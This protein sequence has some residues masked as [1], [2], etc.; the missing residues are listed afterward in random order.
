MK[1]FIMKRRNQ[2]SK[3]PPPVP[4]DNPRVKPKAPPK[5]PKPPSAPVGVGKGGKAAGK[6]KVEIKTFHAAV[7]SG[8][9]Q[10]EKIL[11][12]ADSGLGKSTLGLL[13][14]TPVF[15]GLDDGGRKLVHPITGESPH[16]I[17][18]VE[19]F[20]DF[21]QATQQVDLF[22]DYETVVI[23]TA[24]ILES[25]AHDW[26]LEN[27]TNNKGEFVK[28]IEHYGYGAGHRH[29]YD[30]MRLPLCDFDALVRRGKNILILC[31]MQQI[32]ITNSSGENYLCDAPKLA[33]K[34]GKQTP[35]VWGMWVEWCDHVFKIG[36]SDLKAKDK[37][38]T[39]SSER[40]IFLDG[41]VNFKAKSR[42]VPNQFPLVTFSTPEDDSIWKFIFEDAWRDLLEEK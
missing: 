15:L 13:A 24:T 25:W 5:P 37:K 35:S 6:K 34:H 21:Q 17:E 19:T 1:Y 14:P 3:A 30:T 27:V 40:I 8:E 33:P 9:G 7:W 12:Y 41:N 11:G 38:A 28:T 22:D 42:T 2:M 26:M 20:N 39:A 32:E 10:G 18:G 4:D 23:D 31:Q 36:Y 29:L 16:Y